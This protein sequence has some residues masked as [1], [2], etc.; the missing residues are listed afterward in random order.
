M[1]DA[2]FHDLDLPAPHHHLDVGSGSHAIQTALVMQRLEPVLLE[3]RAD[4]VL[5]Y[6][7]VNSTLAAALTAAKLGMA[8]A[9]VEAGLRSRDRTMPEEINR[10]VTDR[11]AD[12]LF[13]PSRDAVANLREE[14][15]PAERV[16]F[17]GNVMIDTLCWALP[18]AMRRA[19]GPR[20]GVAGRPYVLAT[21]HRPTNVDDGS[22]LAELVGTLADL[23]DQVPV[24]FPLHPRTRRRIEALNGGNG[25][26][27]LRLLTPLGY[28][29]M[30][31]LVA[32]AQFVIT[33]SGGIQEE[34][35]FL[36]VPCLTVRPN[37]ERPITCELGTNQLVPPRR[38]AIL[39]A[40]RGALARRAPPRRPAIE[41]W[42]GRAAE[43][44]AGVLCDGERYV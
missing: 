15:V 20:F 5:V 8:V 27:G 17:V 14:G 11:L 19:P 41:R 26:P 32:G 16:H 25:H 35:T 6:G 33:D 29:D 10:V 2:L 9:H 36:G 1:S 7:D 34:T 4:V 44:I 18:R 21:L 13:A 42:D 22:R 30:V 39:A 3:Q 12:H 28:T 37:T 24:L 43:R 40:A 23:S 38:E 31:G